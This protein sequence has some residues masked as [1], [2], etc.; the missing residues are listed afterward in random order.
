MMHRV[1][2]RDHSSF[3]LTKGF[4]IQQANNGSGQSSGQLSLGDAGNDLATFTPGTG[5][6]GRPNG[7]RPSD[8]GIGHSSCNLPPGTSKT[9]YAGAVKGQQ[10]SGP[11][12]KAD[13]NSGSSICLEYIQPVVEDGRVRVKP[14]PRN[15]RRGLSD[16]GEH[17]CW[18]FCRP[19]IGLS[20][21]EFYCPEAVGQIGAGGGSVI[22]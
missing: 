13:N 3:H 17:S 5:S 12:P 21:S 19:K 1:A 4:V 18:V 14:P 10:R 11:D 16:L 15:C 7:D 20:R 22:R 9:S 8:K 6:N 2:T